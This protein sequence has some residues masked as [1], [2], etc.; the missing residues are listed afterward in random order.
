MLKIDNIT[1]AYKDVPT[2]VDF[3]LDMAPGQIVSLVGES[4]SG[5]SVSSLGM[6]QLIP[7][8]PGR[9]TGGE[10]LY[11]GKDL[12]KASEKEMQKIRGNEISMIFQ[13]PMT[14]LNPIIKC[15][16]QIAESL[17]LHRG[18]KK[19]EAMEEAVRMM[20]AVGIANPEVRAHEYP[21]QMSGGMRQRVMIAMALA[22]QPQI[23]IADEPT[24][25]L[26]V[27]IQAQILDLIR[28]LNESM[29][30]SVVF[31][32]HDL[33]VVSELCDTVK[34]KAVC[35]DDKCIVNIKD[36]G[37]GFEEDRIPY[38][39]DRFETTGSAAAGHAGIGLNLSRLIIE[40]HH[41]TVDVRNNEDGKGAVIRVQIPRYVLKRKAE[42]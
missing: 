36:N 15:G 40:A 6:M 26:D 8:P 21:H 30:T 29:G 11:H 25:A 2:V 22:C 42:L 7:N 9:I 12:V 34:V 17:R 1:I 32:T 19:K 23:L 24:T 13:E 14:S 20:R 31:I 28:E 37:S 18:M 5:K 3:S 10:I 4:G 35:R 27:T 41:G 38:V 16:K 39:F 33:G